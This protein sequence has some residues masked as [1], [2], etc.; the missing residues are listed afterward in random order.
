MYDH[1]EAQLYAEPSLAA[2]HALADIVYSLI[3]RELCAIMP[4]E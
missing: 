2:Y 1:A 3:A 4:W